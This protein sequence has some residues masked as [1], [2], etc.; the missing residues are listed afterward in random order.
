MLDD[1]DFTPLC[2]VFE[3]HAQNGS[4]LLSG[5]LG[6][7]LV[8]TLSKKDQDYLYHVVTKYACVIR[9]RTNQGPHAMLG[10]TCVLVER[11]LNSYSTVCQA[12]Q[13][14]LT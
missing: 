7:T 14:G 9:D 13:D 5:N 8:I 6:Q 4:W 1:S 2:T 12:V 11:C 10:R 3:V